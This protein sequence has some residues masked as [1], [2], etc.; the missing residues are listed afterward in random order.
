M[1]L[2]AFEIIEITHVIAWNLVLIEIICT[3]KQV[4]NGPSEIIH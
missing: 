1:I 2:Q 4:V 3:R